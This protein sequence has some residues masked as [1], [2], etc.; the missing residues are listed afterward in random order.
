M[1]TNEQKVPQNKGQEKDQK[2]GF[3]VD[4]PALRYTR[5]LILEQEDLKRTNHE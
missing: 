5:E 2:T 4:N 3:I 1:D